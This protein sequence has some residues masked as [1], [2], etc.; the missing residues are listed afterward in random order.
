MKLPS[1]HRFSSISEILTSFSLCNLFDM[2]KFDTARDSDR[3]YVPVIFSATLFW[4]ELL[5]TWRMYRVSVTMRTINFGTN[6]EEPWQIHSKF[7]YFLQDMKASQRYRSN[8][9]LLSEAS[10]EMTWSKFVTGVLLSLSFYDFHSSF[11]RFDIM[12]EFQ[13]WRWPL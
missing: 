10:T 13:A 12:I 1:K 4:Q 3:W 7:A 9:S 2:H 5:V 11:W 8:T 6:L